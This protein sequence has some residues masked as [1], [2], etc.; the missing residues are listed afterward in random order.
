MKDLLNQ[1][2]EDHP[3]YQTLT[4][5]Y[6]DFELI[7]QAINHNQ[8]RAEHLAKMVDLKKLIKGFPVCIYHFN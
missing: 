7:S 3:D 2:P 8:R 5:A 6:R 1:T 4:L